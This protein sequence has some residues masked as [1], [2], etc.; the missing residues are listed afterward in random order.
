MYT[1][2][3]AHVVTGFT[4]VTLAIIYG[5]YVINESY[6]SVGTALDAL[7]AG[8]TTVLANLTNVGA[9]IVIVTFNNYRG[10][11]VYK[12]YYTVRTGLYAKTASDTASRVNF[13]NSLFGIDAYRVAG[14]NGSAVTVAK[15]GKIAKSVAGKALICSLA[16]L[17]AVVN[18]LTLLGGTGA[19]AGYVRNLLNNVT[20]FKSH[21]GSD[22]FSGAVTAGNTKRGVGGFSLRKGFRIAVTA[23]KSASAAVCAGETISY[24]GSSLVLLNSKENRGKNK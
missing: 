22:L 21:Y 13:G 11:V 8:Y 12:M 2:H 10:G 16:A 7:A 9:L 20:G 23:G 1:M 24:G 15:A 19:V 6:S 3:G 4:T 18:I 14:T 5:C 17:W